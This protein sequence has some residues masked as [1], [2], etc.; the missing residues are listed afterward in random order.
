MPTDPKAPIPARVPDVVPNPVHAPTPEETP[1][2][3]LPTGV[4]HPGPDILPAPEPQRIPQRC[5]RKS[6][7]R[8]TSPSPAPDS[9]L[10]P[11]G[12]KLGPSRSS[13]A[14]DPE[15]VKVMS[16]ALDAAWVKFDP[17]PK[18]ADL[19]RLHLATAIIDAVEAG[20]REP[21][22]LA[23]STRCARP[24]N[25]PNRRRRARQEKANR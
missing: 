24:P 25:Q 22:V 9:T 23:A 12:G 1:K 7:V 13:G 15:L 14:Y 21:E 10:I 5:R 20:E 6:R 18:D 2:P 11:A 3:D 4:P 8:S 16:D 17:P 19:A